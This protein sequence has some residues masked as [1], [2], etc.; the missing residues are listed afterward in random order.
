MVGWWKRAC[1]FVIGSSLLAAPVAATLCESDPLDETTMDCCRDMTRCNTPG[2]EDPC[3]SPEGR[4]QT[5]DA[6][7]L[8]IGSKEWAVLPSV[9]PSETALTG[10]FAA[11]R[12]LEPSQVL[13]RHPL[14]KPLRI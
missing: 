1:V 5:G 4:N 14:I 9:G 2:V 11:P 10:L 12:L 13:P 3:C 6:T 8:S 7:A